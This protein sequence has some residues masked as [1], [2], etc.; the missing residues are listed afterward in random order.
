MS[1]NSV[2]Y[3]KVGRKARLA[4]LVERSA[5]N[6]VVEGSSPSVGK[7]V[8]IGH[9]NSQI[10]IAGGRR[11]ETCTRKLVSSVEECQHPYLVG[12]IG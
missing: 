10:E 3:I 9:S 4:Q 8:M 6:R 12:S 2:V 7:N 5:F 11:V 1:T